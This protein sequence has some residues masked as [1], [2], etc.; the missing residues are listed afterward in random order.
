[1][2]T[3]EGENLPSTPHSTRSTFTNITT[4]SDPTR[5]HD[6][7]LR[8]NVDTYSITSDISGTSGTSGTPSV[9]STLSRIKRH[10]RPQ[11]IIV[12]MVFNG[13]VLK[14]DVVLSGCGLKLSVGF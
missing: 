4:D 14:L 9:H 11:V 6:A 8:R 10:A 12:G 5:L 13:R 3:T 1:M 7:V 2:D